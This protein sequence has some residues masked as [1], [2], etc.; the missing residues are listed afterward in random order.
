MSAFD[1]QGGQTIWFNGQPV[2]GLK[3]IASI[4]KRPGRQ[5]FWFEGM[6]CADFVPITA[7]N[8]KTK[9]LTILAY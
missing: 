9:F 7:V 5:T 3:V 8:D 6:P 1:P 4:S 2:P